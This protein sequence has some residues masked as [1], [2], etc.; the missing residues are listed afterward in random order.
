[1]ADDWDD[2]RHARIAALRHAAR[3]ERAETIRRLL[4]SLLRRRGAAN[5]VA[6]CA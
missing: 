5:G 1:M 4:Q 2:D 6:H 3:L